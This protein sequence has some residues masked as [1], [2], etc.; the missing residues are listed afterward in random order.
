M[1]LVLHVMTLLVEMLRIRC[2]KGVKTDFKVYAA[3][4]DTYNDALKS[5]IEDSKKLDI[6]RSSKIK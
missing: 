1:A 6:L 4:F 3:R 2:S 5:L